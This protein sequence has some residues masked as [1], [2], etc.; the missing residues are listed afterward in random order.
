MNTNCLLLYHLLFCIF[1][2]TVEEQSSEQVYTDF[3]VVQIS[4][5]ILEAQSIA[6]QLDLEFYGEI[7]NLK[8]LYIFKQHL[9]TSSRRKRRELDNVLKELQLFKNVKTVEPQVRLRRSKRNQINFQDP[10]FSKQWNLHSKC[11][12]D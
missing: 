11:M 1:T 10:S 9:K 3:F 8:D 4:D 6:S 7:G 2:I 5:G 12:D